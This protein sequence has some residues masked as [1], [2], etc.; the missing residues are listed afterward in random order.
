MNQID[1]KRLREQGYGY[2]KISTMLGIS[3]NS[4]K[5]YCKRMES[6]T[7]KDEIVCLHCGKK[8]KEHPLG[9]EKKFCSDTCRLKWWKIHTELLKKKAVYSF[10]CKY[11]GKK[12][13]AYGNNHRIYCSRDC[14]AKARTKGGDINAK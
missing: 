6:I 8:M 4:V 5:S 9:I 2:K 12:F 1:I 13:T 3:I 7:K 14:F 11:C 10:V